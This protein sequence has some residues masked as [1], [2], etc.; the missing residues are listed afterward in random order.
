MILNNGVNMNKLK[1]TLAVLAV[2][3]V[4]CVNAKG[5]AEE[6][7]AHHASSSARI[8][9]QAAMIAAISASRH[10]KDI[11]D[12]KTFVSQY[13]CECY[14]ATPAGCDTGSWKTTNIIPY[15]TWC[16]GVLLNNYGIKNTYLVGLAYDY[17]NNNTT[18][19]MGQNKND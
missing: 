13:Y 7:S 6:A 14:S 18:V 8:G 5:A 15:E 11:A 9:S 12:S 3:A 17:S 16:Q 4:F 2:F 19:Y 10:N 1:L